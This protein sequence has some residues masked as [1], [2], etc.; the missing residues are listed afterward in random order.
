MPL[1]QVGFQG[2]GMAQLVSAWL[3]EQEVPGSDPCS[4][5]FDRALTEGGG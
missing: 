4:Y 3:S 5:S 1:F 2:A